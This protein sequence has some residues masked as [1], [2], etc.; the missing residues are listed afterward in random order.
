MLLDQNTR[1]EM[2]SLFNFWYYLYYTELPL[3]QLPPRLWLSTVDPCAGGRVWRTNSLWTADISVHM[4][5]RRIFSGSQR[6]TRC[7]SDVHAYG[8]SSCE[9]NSTYQQNPPASVISYARS[10]RCVNNSSVGCKTVLIQRPS[11]VV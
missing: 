2:L 6:A 11:P 9:R 10:A 8:N 3:L 4:R 5:S 1:W 7:V